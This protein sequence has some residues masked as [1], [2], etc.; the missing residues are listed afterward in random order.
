MEKELTLSLVWS[1][2]VRSAKSSRNLFLKLLKNIGLFVFSSIFFIFFAIF[3]FVKI[4]VIRVDNKVSF[5]SEKFHQKWY[6]Y[7]LFILTVL[8][9]TLFVI[10]LTH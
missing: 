7:I 10:V 8:F 3:S 9:T 2:I 5:F 6:V 1:C 4:C